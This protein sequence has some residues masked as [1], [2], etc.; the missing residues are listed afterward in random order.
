METEG[1]EREERKDRR[2]VY[3]RAERDAGV[4]RRAT[5]DGQDADRRKSPAAVSTLDKTLKGC[6]PRGRLGRYTV[7]VILTLKGCCCV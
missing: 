5:P 7:A 2:K 6:R 3:K 1:E 4:E